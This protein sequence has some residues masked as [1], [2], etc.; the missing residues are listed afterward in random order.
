MRIEIRV[1]GSDAFY[2]EAVNVSGQHRRLIKKPEAKLRDQFRAFR[3]NTILC[4]IFLTL[5]LVVAF[6]RGADT[7]SWVLA[8][9]MVFCIVLNVSFLLQYHRLLRSLKGT[10]GI[11]VLTLDEQGVELVRSDGVKVRLDW[12]TVAFVRVFE[13]SVCFIPRRTPGIVLS[14]ERS[15]AAPILEALRE[16]APDVKVY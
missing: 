10:E 11:A 15:Y 3:V 4:A 14:V 16:Y 1:P 8:A 9:L 6:T 12:S 7:V 13:H 5:N 2:R